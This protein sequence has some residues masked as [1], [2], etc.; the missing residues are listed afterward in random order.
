MLWVN[1]IMDT[2]ASLALATES[3]SEELLERKPYSRYEYMITPIMFRNVVMMGLFQCV[4]LT[5]FL[6]KGDSMFGFPSGR[7]NPVWTIENG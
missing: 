2:F 5:W 7:Q 3:P 6:F 4:Y 1:L